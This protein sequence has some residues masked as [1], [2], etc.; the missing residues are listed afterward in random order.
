MPQY[1][2][3]GVFI[4]EIAG[5][6]PI[7]GVGTA[8]GAFVGLAERGPIGE[9]VLVTNFTQFTE[10]FG[11]FIANGYLAYSVSQFFLE[12]GTRAWVVRTCHY[13]TI[14]SAASKTAVTSTITLKDRAGTPL[15]TLKIDA[16]SPGSWGDQIGVL[17]SDATQDAANKF[18][19]RIRFRDMEVEDFDGLA[20]DSVMGAING[21]SKYIK[22]T[23]I[24]SATLGA[25][26]RPAN[27]A[28][29]FNG[30]SIW[31]LERGVTVAIAAG[32]SGGGTFKIVVTRGASAEPSFDN[33]TMSDVKTKVN[34]VSRLIAVNV[35]NASSPPT[36]P[37]VATALPFF[38]LSAGWDGLIGLSLVDRAATPVNTL[39][40]S[41]RQDQ[42]TV[43]ITD[44]L[45]D[46]TNRFKIVVKLNGVQKETFDDQT[47]ASV[48][49]AVN[50]ISEYIEVDDLQS[51]SAVPTN[52]PAL[53]G[54]TSVPTGLNDADF[55]GDE[56]AK[57]GMH[58]LDI[59]DDM[60]IL[61]MPDRAGD[62]EVIIGAYTYC[63]NRKDCFFV[64][65]PPFGLSPLQALQFK[66][67]TVD[68]WTGNGFN[69]SYGALY[70]PWIKVSDPL[71]GKT[72]D[73]PPSG[74]VVGTYSFTDVQRG[75][76]KAPAGITEGYLNSAVGIER[77]ITRGE[78]EL[79]NPNGINAIRQFPS[80]G[81]VVWG[82]RTLSADAEWKY[83]NVRRLILFI[84]ESIEDGSQWV[85]FEPN[86]RSL[87]AKV[88]RDVTAF[89]T[90]VWQS[91]ALFGATPQEAFYVKIDDENNPQETRDLGR[92]IIDIGVAPTK[93][94][95]FV[96]FRITQKTQGAKA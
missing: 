25:T 19:L 6:K 36:I 63:Q 72:K 47:M 12:G 30:L 75:V 8:T 13:T 96:I 58:A 67:G 89:L 78:Q 85:V 40:V 44:P 2:A 81:I 27:S 82:A 80:A 93:P 17:V 1:L 51:G 48:E 41:A 24:P 61:A 22:V 90:V 86:D 70:Y 66:Q 54:D 68:P 69:T 76:H 52:R 42:V 88:K 84:E 15:D 4:E 11:G 7:E 49:E 71:T 56:G 73:V 64:A 74:A 3:P 45:N 46:P 77:Q 23:D 65:D 33:L 18:R 26:K 20:V 37:T 29:A 9:A 21:A 43:A 79:L 28:V 57:N 59:I 5:A 62:R 38:A 55:L 39:R 50:G 60:N 32:T 92:L 91:G 94:A 87:W 83:V 95:E 16:L 10:T 14:T 34:G 35:T 53:M 31:A